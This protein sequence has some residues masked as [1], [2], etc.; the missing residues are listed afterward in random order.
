MHQLIYCHIRSYLLAKDCNKLSV[1]E[2]LVVPEKDRN[3]LSFPQS[4]SS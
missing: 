4:L 1:L 2:T 3:N